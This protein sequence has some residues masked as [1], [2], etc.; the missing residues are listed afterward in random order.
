[1]CHVGEKSMQVRNIGYQRIEQDKYNQNM[2]QQKGMC[3]GSS[4]M[5]FRNAE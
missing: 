4:P 5:L 1:M 2:G 3:I